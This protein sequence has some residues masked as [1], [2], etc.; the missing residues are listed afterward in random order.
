[1]C[2]CV[3]VCVCVCWNLINDHVQGLEYCPVFQILLHTLVTA[4]HLLQ[5]GTLSAPA[6]VCLS[7]TFS[8]SPACCL[9]T[10][11]LPSS[12]LLLLCGTFSTDWSPFCCFCLNYPAS[13]SLN[14]SAAHSCTAFFT[15]LLILLFTSQHL[16]DPS[17]ILYHSCQEVLNW[18][19]NGFLFGLSFPNTWLSPLQQ[20]WEVV[21]VSSL[22]VSSLSVRS[23]LSISR[24]LLCPKGHKKAR[25]LILASTELYGSGWVCYVS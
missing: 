21:T 18:K 12:A 8:T 6:A 14:W 7:N 2:V 4:S 17:V 22:L 23:W 5:L 9:R 1:M 13:T 25:S 15:A 20:C 10:E 3:C 16:C 24:I 11:S 19:T